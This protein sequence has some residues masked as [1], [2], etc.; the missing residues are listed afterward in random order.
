MNSPGVCVCVWSVIGQQALVE[1]ERIRRQQQEQETAPSVRGDKVSRLSA[2]YFISL[3][4]DSNSH[5]QIP[6]ARAYYILCMKQ[7]YWGY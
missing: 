4:C 6:F 1:Q 3:Y 5:S 7:V 2:D